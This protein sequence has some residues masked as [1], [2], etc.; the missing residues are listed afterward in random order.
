M[1]P[2]VICVEDFEFADYIV[3]LMI[4]DEVDKSMTRTRL[5]VLNV[6]RRNLSNLKQTH[7]AIVVN[8][9]TAL[10]AATW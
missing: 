8:D 10:D 1:D 6:F 9:S 4:D 5:E 3:S 2:N 7:L